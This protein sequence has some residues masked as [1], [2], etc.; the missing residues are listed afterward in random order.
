MKIRPEEITSILRKQI[1]EY[2]VETDLAEVG[3]VL[4]VGDGIARIYGLESAVALEM[5]ELEHGVTGLAFN[6]EEDNVGAALF[7]EWEKIKEGDSAKRTGRVASIPVGDA[8][9]G[10]IVDPLGNA[11]DGGPPI[12]TDERRPLEFKAPGV[13]DRQPVKEP[14][15]TGIKA[16]DTMTNVGRG[17][18]ELIIGDRS[19]GKTAILVDTILN[20]R[21]QDM[22]CIYVAI[23]QKSSTVAQVYERLKEAGAMEYTIIVT[24]P[25]SEAAPI[26][27]M[28]PFAGA[29]MGEHFMFGGRHAVCMYDDL[30]KHADAYRQMSLLLRRPPGREAFPGDVFYLHSRLLERACKLSD[31]RGAGSLTALP[32]I[33]TQAGDIAAYIPTNVISIT[34]GQIFLE[35]D[36]FFSGVRPAVNVGRSVSRV[37]ASAQTKAMKKVAGRLRLELSQ[38]RELEAFAQFGSELD[39][40]TQ[41]SLARGE[42]MVATLNQPQYAPWPM[43]E[44]VI[45]IYAGINGFLDDVPVAGHPAIPGRAP[46]A[47]AHRGLDL[48]GDRRVRRPLGRAHGEAERGD[49]EVQAGLQHLRGARSRRGRELAITH[50]DRSG[51]QAPRPLRP[52]HTEDHARDGAGRGREAAARP[53]PD[54]GD[55]PLRRAH[56]GADGRRRAR[57]HLAPGSPVAPAAGRAEGGDPAADR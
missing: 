30:S 50:G 3:T 13:V 9:I 37:G 5:L 57:E 4:Q 21:G 10:R 7:G 18:R 47:P 20:Q 17:Q 26:K 19:T 27:W 35:A 39:P 11:I 40:A 25:A 43:E 31:A 45:A 56:A 15:Q 22:I 14:L 44:Q 29:A 23:G 51:D 33:E 8:L 28:A 2:D 41:A 46:R 54:R 55:A 32:V 34:D 42:R 53:D 16:I 48:Q 6:L 1:E 52:E 12:E 36:L 24:A 38:Y 49:R